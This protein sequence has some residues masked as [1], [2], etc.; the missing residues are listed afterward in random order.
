MSARVYCIFI[1]KMELIRCIICICKSE[2]LLIRQ[3]LYAI[4]FFYNTIE[5]IICSS[6]YET[7]Y[8][9]ILYLK[10]ITLY[11][12]FK[13]LICSIKKNSILNV[14]TIYS[15]L[16]ALSNIHNFFNLSFL[17][18]SSINLLSTPSFLL[19]VFYYLLKKGLIP[20]YKLTKNSLQ[21]I[22][23]L[24]IVL[25]KNKYKPNSNYIIR[26]LIVQMAIYLL[27]KPYFYKKC[28]FTSF[29][30][31]KSNDY[32]N[33]FYHIKKYWKNIKGFILFNFKEIKIS[34]LKYLII[35][36]ISNLN[37]NIKKLFIL[38][39]KFLYFFNTKNIK[40]FYIIHTLFISIIYLYF[41]KYIYTFYKLYYI[42]YFYYFLIGVT[43]DFIATSLIALYYNIT[44]NILHG[45]ELF[46]RISISSYFF[47]PISISI[48]SNSISFLNYNICISTYF[49]KLC[50]NYIHLLFFVSIKSIFSKFKILGFVKFISNKFVITAMYKW[51]NLT[52]LQIIKKYNSIIIGI[53]KYY[54]FSDNFYSLYKILHI[55]KKSAIL[56]IQFHKK[57]STLNF[58][59]YKYNKNCI[60]YDGVK[61]ISLFDFTN[62]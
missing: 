54:I 8:N 29:G 36:I 52:Y 49:D 53:Y 48:K 3:T 1:R 60:I 9:Y 11:I 56:T 18:N 27:F 20:I 50:K 34:K 45:F 37:K 7:S 61:L 41:D 25:H 24:S 55:L 42:R 26:D 16:Y 35:S 21:T 6:L 51:I 4:F 22:F 40:S 59:F 47:L 2:M 23:K 28:N 10:S 5:G 17:N 57:T 43:F 15:S 13:Y 12:K 32:V 30:L 38:F 33:C 58:T 14:D 39:F 31:K 44:Q 19:I 62:F 46:F